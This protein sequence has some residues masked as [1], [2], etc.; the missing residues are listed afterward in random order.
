MLDINKMHIELGLKIFFILR[1]SK[2]ENNNRSD[3]LICEKL[4]FE[5]CPKLLTET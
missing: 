3:K 4:L 5:V 2:L 1:Q